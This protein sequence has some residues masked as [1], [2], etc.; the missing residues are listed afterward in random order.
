[1]GSHVVAF[2]LTTCLELIARSVQRVH[3][4][5]QR[6]HRSVQ[7]VQQGQP[8]DTKKASELDFDE[9]PGLVAGLGW[10]LERRG[11]VAGQDARSAE[12]GLT[13]GAK[14]KDPRQHSRAL[15]P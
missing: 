10:V 15:G 6:V 4:S 2:H 14:R 3:R 9:A 1:M 11:L 7:R 13:M 12:P 8:A 5:V